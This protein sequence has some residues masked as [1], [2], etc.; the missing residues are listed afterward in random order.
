MQHPGG[1]RT[2][3]A[4][5]H[6]A[7]RRRSG[8]TNAYRCAADGN[9]DNAANGNAG[10]T[11]GNTCTANGNTGTDHRGGCAGARRVDITSCSGNV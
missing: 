5:D 11:D 2:T 6:G 1:N 3:L 7:A 4:H 10:T 8:V 9:S